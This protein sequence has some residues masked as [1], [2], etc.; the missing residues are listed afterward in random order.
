VIALSNGNYEYK[1]LVNKKWM[2][3][4]KKQV[5]E[6][7]NHT[8]SVNPSSQKYLHKTLEALRKKG[9]M[10]REKYFLYN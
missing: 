2:T 1:Y 8:L 4:S 6:N 3:D 7:G 9:G 5:N 10:F